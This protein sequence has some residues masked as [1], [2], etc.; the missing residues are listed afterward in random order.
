MANILLVVFVVFDL[1][2][3]M[4]EDFAHLKRLHLLASRT[5][6]NTKA[7]VVAVVAERRPTIL[8]GD[9]PTTATEHGV[10]A[11]WGSVT[12]PLGYAP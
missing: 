12:A 3:P 7:V 10:R 1:L 9:P 8:D 2:E 5:L 11:S 4:L 6:L